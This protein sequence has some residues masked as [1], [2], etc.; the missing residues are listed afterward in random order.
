MISDLDLFSESSN[1]MI[2][3]LVFSSSNFPS[4]HIYDNNII[5]N[6]EY[7][8]IFYMEKNGLASHPFKSDNILFR[9]Y[10]KFLRVT[11]YIRRVPSTASVLSPEKAIRIIKVNFFVKSQ[12]LGG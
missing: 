4:N 5:T 1:F 11:P 10:H 8:E 7:Y 3:N 6:H 12:K 9:S 2:M